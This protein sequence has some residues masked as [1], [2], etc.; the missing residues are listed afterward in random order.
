MSQLVLPGSTFANVDAA[1]NEVMLKAGGQFLAN[2]F[3]AAYVAGSLGSALASQAAVSRI[4]YTMGRDR[5]LPQ[6]TFGHLSPRWVRR[7][8]PSCWCRRSRCWRW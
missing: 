3:T 4:L 7:C 6:R 2:F 8:S 5:V 1:A